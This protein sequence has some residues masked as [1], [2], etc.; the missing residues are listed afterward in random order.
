MPS[1]WDDARRAA[2]SAGVALEPLTGLDG[3]LEA[4]GV[5]T[6]VWGEEAAAVHYLRA[7]EHA[8][9]VFYAARADGALVGFV[10]GF[11]GMAGGPHLHSHM[12]AVVPGRRAKGV[13]FAL[14][15][16][17]R[18]AC[19]DAGVHD[20]RWTFDPMVSANARFNL[21]RLGAVAAAWLPNFYGEM[22]D[23]I[24]RGERSDRFEVRWRLD[25][26]RVAR[27][28]RGEPEAP[29]T[30]PALLEAGSDGE[31]FDAQ[32]M[33]EP[34]CTVAVPPNH[35]SMRRAD[36]ELARAWRAAAGRA[37]E[38]CFGAGLVASWMTEDRR[39]V[40]TEPEA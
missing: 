11:L 14:K 24:N 6:V 27:S 10:L 36:R 28:I 35:V 3:V 23:D 16:A 32:G 8:G 9:S 29:A 25:G 19:L 34:G 40:F 26:E 39:Y 20:A 4:A 17:Q 12:L 18:A 1:A 13:G 37:F 30:G 31:P 15:L 22:P 33:P 2:E 5:I 21:V 7:I 38:A